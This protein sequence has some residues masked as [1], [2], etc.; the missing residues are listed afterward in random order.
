MK[1]VRFVAAASAFAASISNAWAGEPIKPPPG[2]SVEQRDKDIVIFSQE[3]ERAHA[4]AFQ[5]VG[6]ADATPEMVFKVVTDVEAH[7]KFMP[8]T[9]ESRIVQRL[10][11]N[12]VIAYQLIAPPLVSQ[13]DY[14]LHIKLTPAT[15]GSNGVYRSEWTT[16]PNFEPE[17]KGIV[18][19]PVAEGSWLFE[20]LDGGKRTRITYTSL[21]NIGGAIPGWMANMSN[22]RI[23]PGI[24]QAVRQRV[25]DVLKAGTPGASSP[26]K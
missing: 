11:A 6:E 13:R 5:A 26:A 3:S 25:V 20:P 14:D 8:F 23:I 10:N 12:E 22:M 21:T 19:M 18:R 24:F 4:R 2:W 15:P 17:R 16:V 7:P 1:A 9:K